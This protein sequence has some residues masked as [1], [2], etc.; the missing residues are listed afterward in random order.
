MGGALVKIQWL[1]NLASR[2]H[3]LECRPRGS[4]RVL[5]CA[6]STGKVVESDGALSLAELSAKPTVTIDSVCDLDTF[7]T[8]LSLCPF[9]CQVWVNCLQA[10]LL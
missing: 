9:I 6:V 5:V 4:Q 7:Q 2:Q 10:R 3:H 8:S 1:P